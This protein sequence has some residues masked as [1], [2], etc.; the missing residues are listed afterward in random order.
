MRRSDPSIAPQAD[1]L[2]SPRRL[3]LS[4]RFSLAVS[5]PALVLAVGSLTA[6]R[7]YVSTKAA[8]HALS[9]SVSSHAAVQA[10]EQTTSALGGA[11]PA[12]EVLTKLSAAHHRAD[13]HDGERTRR[14]LATLEANPVFAWVGY[15]DARQHGL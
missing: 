1:P 7:S 13:A 5:I 6:V 9:E 10:E 11:V 2:K 8:V 15:G 3:R 12:L 14:R 4:C